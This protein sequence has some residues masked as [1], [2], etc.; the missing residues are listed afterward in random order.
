M[1]QKTAPIRNTARKPIRKVTRVKKNKNKIFDIYLGISFSGIILGI[2]MIAF[3]FSDLIIQFS[4]ITTIVLVVGV[5]MNI[6]IL[7]LGLKKNAKGENLISEIGTVFYILLNF[8]GGGIFITGLFLMLNFAGRSVETHS[9]HY[10]ILKRDSN[11]RAGTY[12]GVVYNLK[13][14]KLPNEVDHRW[15]D[16]KSI[17][18]I[19][20]KKHLEIKYSSGLFGIDIFEER[21]ITSDLSGSD[22]VETPLLGDGF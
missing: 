11:Y 17:G 7:P 14:Y 22:Y 15:F 1:N 21:G 6:A 16:L 3:F 18:E 13:D 12:N 19:S 9:E 10:E 4:T 20:R 5:F 8:F 2:F